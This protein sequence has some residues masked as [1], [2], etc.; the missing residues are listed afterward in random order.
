[1]ATLITYQDLKDARDNGTLTV[2][3]E[4]EVSD[5]PSFHPIVEAVA[6]DE[7]SEGGTTNDGKTI[8]YSVDCDNPN[9]PAGFKG[10]VIYMSNGNV[11]AWFD[12]V[13]YGTVGNS[14]N[15]RIGPTFD[16]D[17]YRT[18][19][20][21]AIVQ[22]SNV[23]VYGDNTLDIIGC[24]NAIVGSGNS[25]ELRGCK[26]ITVGDNNASLS[27]QSVTGC[28]IGNGNSNITVTAD[29]TEIGDNNQNVTIS[30]PN[31]SVGTGNRV[32]NVTTD[33]FDIDNECVKVDV[34]ARYNK[35]SNVKYADIKAPYNT[36]T[37]SNSVELVD[38]V[39]NKIDGSRLVYLRDVNDND[40][41]TSDF[42]QDTHQY[43]R[44]DGT[45]VQY[46]TPDP[47]PFVRIRPNNWQ[48]PYRVAD[49]LI[50]GMT[51]QANNFGVVVDKTTQER[52]SNSIAQRYYLADGVW[53]LEDE[54]TQT[55]YVTMVMPKSDSSKVAVSGWG[56]YAI[57]TTATLDF[58]YVKGGCWAEFVDQNGTHHT[59]PYSFIMSADT[60]V[61]VSVYTVPNDEIW[62]T[63]TDSQTITPYN[64]N[65]FGGATIQSNTYSGGKGVIKFNQP[66]TAVG[67]QALYACSNLASISLPG[68]VTSIGFAA[69]HQTALSSFVVP[70]S[71][72]SIGNSILSGNPGLEAITVDSAN[73]V[74]DSRDNCNGIV[75]TASD[76]LI[77]G[78]KNTVIPKSVTKVGG[79]AFNGCSSLAAITIPALVTNI[80][81]FAFYSCSSLAS[82]TFESTTTVPTL[83]GSVFTSL[84][85]NGTVYGQSG[86]DY[87][88]VMSALPNSWTLIQ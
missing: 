3:T 78:C 33:E 8:L 61:G 71:V 53:T 44:P 2:G 62:Y 4:Y 36:V 42:I 75:Q 73:T 68:T 9:P 52:V 38:S 23:V 88:S 32:I 43:T 77:M 54:Q 22:C 18:P 29:D 40:I 26:Y 24:Q 69:L 80:G 86:L 10:L 48:K 65:N 87:S 58:I 12:W 81:N 56:E 25:G 21:G 85:N 45:T 7:L 41:Y 30:A 50:G 66:L 37:D 55:A 70:A 72:T 13:N 83:A 5:Y 64:P 1:M 49:S 47:Q 67:N 14:S 20:Q 51:R 17:G 57:G 46:N 63:T 34:S 82:I 60:Q 84:P 19:Y 28:K 76:T 74:Y 59:A 11:E 39:G 6:V 79:Y 16:S 15:V 31:G 27:V 35:I